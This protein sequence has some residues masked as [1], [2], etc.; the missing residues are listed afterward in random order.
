M[1]NKNKKRATGM[2]EPRLE[3]TH[4]GTPSVATPRR[5]LLDGLLSPRS[6]DSSMPTKSTSLWR[7][8]IS[9]ATS[10]GLMALT[11]GVT[12]AGWIGAITLGFQGPFS[13]MASFLALPP[14]GTSF[15]I[16]MTS[17]LFAG[18]GLIG[19]SIHPFSVQG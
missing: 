19:V 7:G 14:I 12:L 3:S 15:D 17:R 11:I 13:V 18:S 5:G 6:A 4:R 2:R 10:P 9:T 8:L 1:T 16:A